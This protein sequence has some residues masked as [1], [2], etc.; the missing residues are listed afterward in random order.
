MNGD[1]GI[2]PIVGYRIWA[3]QRTTER[4][5]L[6]PLSRE[7]V[8]RPGYPTWGAVDTGHGVYACRDLKAAEDMLV[9]AAH[10]VTAPYVIGEVSLWGKIHVHAEG[11]RAEFGYPKTLYYNTSTHP[12]AIQRDRS[13]AQ[14]VAQ[15]YGCEIAGYEYPILHTASADPTP[16]E[17]K[18]ARARWREENKARREE[19]AKARAEAVQ[20]MVTAL[21]KDGGNWS[22]FFVRRTAYHIVIRGCT[23]AQARWRV[24]DEAT[25][26]RMQNPKDAIHRWKVKRNNIATSYDL[27]MKRFEWKN[28]TVRDLLAKQPDV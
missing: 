23:Y 1:V 12:L 9:L 17:L 7:S 3:L 20:N 24:I 8:W 4:I 11:Y 27:A 28:K 18:A 19:N 10:E 14:E 22:Q 15:T 13:V 5:Y 21:G 25:R 26:L 16:A 6:V 2:E